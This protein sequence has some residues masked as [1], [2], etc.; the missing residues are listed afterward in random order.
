[1]MRSIT[2]VLNYGIDY[3]LLKGY[4]FLIVLMTVIIQAGLAPVL[5]K[6]CDVC[7]VQYGESDAAENESS[8]NQSAKDG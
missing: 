1:M 8:L 4:I 7:T 6:T 3:P 5:A 2:L